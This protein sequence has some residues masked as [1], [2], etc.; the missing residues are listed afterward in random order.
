MTKLINKS[1]EK[2]L[3]IDTT[4]NY[5]IKNFNLNEFTLNQE[6]FLSNKDYMDFIKLKLLENNELIKNFNDKT[7]QFL[8]YEHTFDFFNKYKRLPYNSNEFPKY[9]NINNDLNKNVDVKNNYKTF[10]LKHIYTI[11]QNKEIQNIQNLYQY[12]KKDYYID[13]IK[14]YKRKTNY[15]PLDN[16]YFRNSNNDFPR[17][18]NGKRIDSNSDVKVFYDFL[19]KNNNF[20]KFSI[21]NDTI[22][23]IENENKKY[24]KIS[25]VKN[26]NNNAKYV[27]LLIYEYYKLN[28][29]KYPELNDFKKNSI[30]PY[31]VGIS[32]DGNELKYENL[33]N[34]NEI[35]DKFSENEIKKIFSNIKKSLKTKIDLEE[36]EENEEVAEHKKN[37]IKAE[38]IF[39][40]II[41]KILSKN[42]E[43]SN[44]NWDSF[45][46]N[47]IGTNSDIFYQNFKNDLNKDEI[48]LFNKN[49][50]IFNNDIINFFQILLEESNKSIKFTNL[51][52][53]NLNEE[54]KNKK[55]YDFSVEN[56]ENKKRIF[57]SYKFKKGRSFSNLSIDIFFNN[58]NIEINIDKE[59]ENYIKQIDIY[60]YENYL[61]DTYNEMIDYIMNKIE[62]EH[63]KKDNQINTEENFN[64]IVFNM[65]GKNYKNTIKNFKY[66]TLNKL[67]NLS[68]K[69]K[70]KLNTSMFKNIVINNIYG[71]LTDESI[72]NFEL[73]INNKIEIKKNIIENIE[74]DNKNILSYSFFKK[75]N[76]KTIYKYVIKNIYRDKEISKTVSDNLCFGE[77]IDLEMYK[78]ILKNYQTYLK[79]LSNDIDNN[80][81]Y[82]FDFLSYIL[83]FTSKSEN[84]MIENQS[85]YKMLK[86]EKVKEKIKDMK[87]EFSNIIP[88]NSFISFNLKI[89]YKGKLLYEFKDN[90][91]KSK[92]G[93][94]MYL[95]CV[96]ISNNYTLDEDLVLNINNEENKNKIEQKLIIN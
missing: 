38:D 31:I 32:K 23:I 92:D 64:E 93:K 24:Y 22:N 78:I 83:H 2:I 59:K 13:Q 19:F 42:L 5:P 16:K 66:K 86:K 43:I 25:D 85:F 35:K 11:I 72:N 77:K 65:I 60:V 71:V 30:F 15:F 9:L 40:K 1:I 18:F 57:L 96:E 88:K 76:N 6:K 91:L 36:N 46:N 61:K 12:A 49:K 3:N 55:G 39:E 50:L 45:I 51:N 34:E 48:N 20:E 44:E 87:I 4:L 70:G 69:E 21:E 75:E 56:L 74:K 63:L 41:N 28:H 94:L 47:I 8:I 67:N 90:Q 95:N 81:N 73:F 7:I 26:N 82:K 58:E 10:Y 37:A 68:E 62:N 53:K 27:L 84:Y 14:K 52:F 17:S 79:K 29:G 54:E 80:E 89:S 33:F